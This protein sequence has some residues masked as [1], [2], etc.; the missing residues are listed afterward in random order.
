MLK[1]FSYSRQKVSTDL[2]QLKVVEEIGVNILLPC[3]SD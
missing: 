3:I 2:N 1:Y